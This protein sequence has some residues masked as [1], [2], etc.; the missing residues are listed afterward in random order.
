MKKSIKILTA[1]VLVLTQVLSF[2]PQISV[3]AASQIDSPEPIANT[4]IL[5]AANSAWKYLDN[6]SNQGTAW[7]APNFNDGSWA[8][9]LAELGYG[10]GNEA[11]VV[12]FGPDSSNKYTTTYFRQKFNVSDPLKYNGIIARIV[13]DDGAAVYINGQETFRSNMPSGDIN[14]QT[15]ASS[16]VGGSDESAYQ[17][18][19]IDSSCLVS[20]ENTVAVE[21][22][23][24]R[25]DSSDIS[26]MLELAGVLSTSPSFV[27]SPTPTV[28]S[29]P[30]AVPTV[31]SYTSSDI[32]LNIGK[33][34]TE[35]N[36]SWYSDELSASSK[37]QVAKKSDMTGNEFPASQAGTFSGTVSPAVTGYYSNK[38][39][40]T[41]LQ[42]STQYV[43]R[44]GDGNEANWSPVYSFT[45][46][47]TEQFGFIAVGDPQ[48]GA[49][50]ATTD[51]IGWKDTMSKAL[52]K[53]PDIS[54][55]M[56]AGDQVENNNNESQYTGYFAPAELRSLP[57]APALGNHDNGANNYGYHYNLPNLSSQYGITTPGSSDYYYTYG[58]VLFMVLNT[59][60]TS[61]AS[62]KAFMQEA[63]SANPD[64][65]WKVVMFHQ[66]IYS[67]A[68]HST[69]T[70]I[71]NLRAALFPVFDELG[72]DMV[73]MGHDHCYTRSYQ[74]KGDV[75]Q[76]DQVV[77]ASGAVVNPTG[78]LYITLNSASGSKY[79]DLKANPEAYAA[80]RTQIKVPTFSYIKVDGNK[81]SIS[82]YR[83]DT[84]AQTDTYSIVKNAVV[85][86]GTA[87]SN[88]GKTASVKVS[89]NNIKQLGGLKVKLS[90][91]SSKLSLENVV[92]APQLFTSALNTSVDGEICFNAVDSDGLTSESMDIATITYKVN[93]NVELSDI[94]IKVSLAEACDVNGQSAAITP[95]DGSVKVVAPILPLASNVT[96]T[97]EAVAGKVLTAQYAYSDSLNRPEAGTTFRWL[98][99]DHGTGNYI[100]IEGAE[101]KT[102]TVTKDLTGKD[103]KVEVTPCNSEDKGLAVS[104]DNGRNAVISLGDVNK[105][106]AV[107]FVD[108][109]LTLQSITGKYTFGDKQA[110]SAAD[111]TFSDGININD[112][113]QILKSDVG[114]ISLN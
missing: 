18:Y 90:Y 47:D 7:Y 22:H 91:D 34:A 62:H 30:T 52:S 98:A 12:S 80:V 44:L 106:G 71:V 56:S 9:G 57:F 33:D 46:R 59:N 25:P 37:V 50:N 8:S 84:M 53:F 110:E 75:P 6:N 99:A 38:V 16:T 96:F 109:L 10:D 102:F 21:V 19:N 23:Q 64:A 104:G 15:N 31:S 92:L 67:S 54:F 61:G 5:V 40:V 58:N 77:D 13:R 42:E 93:Q 17:T 14:Y 69:E 78:T 43:Y 108:A 88:P 87:T 48:I 74:M 103:I 111:V 1:L 83:T 29:V 65:A 85:K 81:L 107:N 28:T 79:Y 113:I 76:K 82:T 2:L 41:G 45:T 3:F 95:V 100:A 66:A 86:V 94:P 60:N 51:T 73:L 27:P 72:V 63:I 20:G 112:V 89:V 36:F 105:D 4:D 114:I 26:F 35:I 68:S 70:A 32:A 24:D 39:T 101:N 49:G 55:M 97:G 11:T